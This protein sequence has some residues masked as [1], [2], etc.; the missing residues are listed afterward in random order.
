MITAYQPG[1]RV[2]EACIICQYNDI[3][4]YIYLVRCQD[5]HCSYEQF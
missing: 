1:E 3:S 5:M 4:E 2:L